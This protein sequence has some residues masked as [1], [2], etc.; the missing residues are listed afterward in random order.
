[1][2]AHKFDLH[3]NL[4]YMFVKILLVN[5]ISIFNLINILSIKRHNLNLNSNHRWRIYL[6]KFRIGYY[7]IAKL[8]KFLN[9]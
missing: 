5:E 3:L 6:I 1:M 2:Y 9:I 8:I 7:C 4:R